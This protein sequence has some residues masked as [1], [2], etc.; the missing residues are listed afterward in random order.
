MLLPFALAVASFSP[1]SSS[2]GLKCGTATE[3]TLVVSWD[4]VNDT[5]LYYV[6]IAADAASRPLA[7]QTSASTET[8]LIDL[9]PGTNYYLTIRSHPSENNIVWGWR[10]ATQPVRCATMAARAIRFKPLRLAY[11]TWH[12]VLAQKAEDLL[13]LHGAL[14]TMS[15]GK[16]RGVGPR[17]V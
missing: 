11:N 4:V 5:D 16:V 2:G 7:L 15:G 9:V 6:G 3:T 10:A 17:S 12:G 8:T 1:A 13:K 14:R